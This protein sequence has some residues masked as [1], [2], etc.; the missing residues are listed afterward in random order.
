MG[1]GGRAEDCFL[2]GMFSRLD[3]MLGR[4]IDELL[5]GLNLHEDITFALLER[6]RPGNRMAEVW[7]LVKAYE[8]ADWAG[9]RAITE[10]KGVKPDSFPDCYADAVHWADTACRM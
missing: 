6:A 7:E 1:L 8:K 4:P 2:M 10:P 9:L 5:D 3:A